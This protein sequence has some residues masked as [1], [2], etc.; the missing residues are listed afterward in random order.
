MIEVIV[1][2]ECPYCEKQVRIMKEAFFDDEW[3]VVDAGSDEFQDHDCRDI[4][5]AFPCV[6]VR[7]GGHVRHA[8]IGVVSGDELRQIERA[9]KFASLFGSSG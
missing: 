3:T 9:A 1:C 8:A 7:E 4:A 2:D 5:E 6:V